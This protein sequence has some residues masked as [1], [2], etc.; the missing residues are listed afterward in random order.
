MKKL[1]VAATMTALSFGAFA[2]GTIWIN[3]SRNQLVVTAYNNA[4][5]PVGTHVAFY[6]SPT[7]ITDPLSAA[8]HLI[9]NGVGV[10]APV[11]GRFALGARTTDT[12]AAPGSTIYVSVR[13][14][15]GNYTDW[16]SAYAAALSDP[17]VAFGYTAVFQMD[18][19][20][21]G[22]PPKPAVALS[23]V[24]GFTGLVIGMPE[25]TTFALAG[26]GAAALLLFRRR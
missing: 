26:L 18:T 14:W 19:G 9:P 8:M 20:G 5:A 7:A 24:S 4:P 23:G 17:N 25:P 16:D 13:G 2:Q 1:V 12:D 10:V 21:A 22:S 15:T 11:P 6:Y 3:N